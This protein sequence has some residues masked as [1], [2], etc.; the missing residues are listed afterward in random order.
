[1]KK[2]VIKLEKINTSQIVSIRVCKFE[3]KLLTK[4]V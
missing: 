3:S 2:G 4:L 1:M